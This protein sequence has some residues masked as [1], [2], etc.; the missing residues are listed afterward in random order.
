VLLFLTPFAYK[1]ETTLPVYELILILIW[2]CIWEASDIV[3]FKCGKIRNQ[4]INMLRLYNAKITFIKDTQII[5]K[6]TVFL[7]KATIITDKSTVYAG[8]SSTKEQNGKLGTKKDS[9]LLFAKLN[10]T[11]ENRASLQNSKQ[12]ENTSKGLQSKQGLTKEQL[13]SLLERHKKDAKKQE[14]SKT[15]KNKQ[16]PKN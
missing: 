8:K 15:N 14:R 6:T 7:D 1:I 13:I 11:K 10:S 2:F 9:D 4:R 3:I 16:V 5:P 12:A